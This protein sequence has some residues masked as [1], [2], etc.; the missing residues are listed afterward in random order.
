MTNKLR[1]VAT[2]SC[3]LCLALLAIGLVANSVIGPLLLDTI[4]YHGTGLLRDRFAGVDGVALVLAAP[5]V[6][7][8]TTERATTEGRDAHTIRG[9]FG[10]SN[11]F[12]LIHGSD[13][14]EPAE[15]ELKLFFKPGE[16]LNFPRAIEGW[17]YDLSGGKAE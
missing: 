10:V 15:K 4:H 11:S 17:V 14:P 3:R 2:Y 12:N 7:C 5:I 1:P 6:G 9:D 8:A 16:V 13:G